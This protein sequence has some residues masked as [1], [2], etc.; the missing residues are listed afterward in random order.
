VD[1]PAGRRALAIVALMAGSGVCAFFLRAYRPSLHLLSETATAALPALIVALA[2]YAV[3]AGSLSLLRARAEL[4]ET[5]LIGFGAFGTLC[6]AIAWFSVMPIPFVAL[7]AAL[8]AIPLLWLHRPAFTALPASVA[9]LVPP[10]LFAIAGALTPVI[11]PDELIYKLA[12]PHAYSL[13]GRMVEMPLNSHS[14][15][16]MANGLA[17]LPALMLGGGVSAKLVHVVIFV[18]ALV[19]I[20]RLAKRVDE[21]SA[22]WVVI[23]FAWTPALMI[24]AG[25]AFSEWAVLALLVISYERYDRWLSSGLAGD[26]AVAA[27]AMGSAAAIK[28][29]ALPWIAAFALIALWRSRSQLRPIV[30][31]IGIVLFFGVFFYVRNVVWTGSPVAPMGLPDAPAVAQYRAGSVVEGWAGF[32][33][34]ADIFDGRVSDEALGILLPLFAIGAIAA[35]FRWRERVIGDLL[36]IGAAQ[37]IVLLSL[38]PTSRNMINGFAALAIPGGAA[39]AGAILLSPMVVRVIASIVVAVS[40][41]AHLVLSAATLSTVLPYLT[42]NETTAQFLLRTGVYARPYAWIA[43]NLPPHAKVLLI[44]ET[45]TFHLQR[46]FVSGG[47][48]DGPRIASWLSQ[49]ATPEAFARGLRDAAVSHVLFHPGR[50]R[51]GVAPEGLVE[52]EVVLTV[53]STTDAMLRSF[54]QSHAD[55]RYSDGTTYVFE[56]R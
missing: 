14:Y 13:E 37:M 54:F 38:G 42:G 15:F 1:L 49:F 26:L 4:D 17:L 48:L 2:S 40:L 18:A 53:P 20:H 25:M 33:R 35:A 11:S 27:A 7:L 24:T 45:R 31:A 10:L 29:T 12:I 51:V 5:F 8:A 46:P 55:L 16:V 9:F 28:Y 34:G 21:R 30:K 3:G 56:V 41:A 23:A 22:M 44:G 36:L 50:Y 47:N 52:R 19:A 6:G 43:Q 32:F 39:V